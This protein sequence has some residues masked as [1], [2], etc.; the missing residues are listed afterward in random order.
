MPRVLRCV[1]LHTALQSLASV[2]DAPA[3][4]VRRAL[5]PAV[6]LALTDHRD[7]IGALATTLSRELGGVAHPPDKVHYFHGSRA[8]NPATF[9]SDGLHPLLASLD[10]VWSELAGLAPEI[11]A[12]D[13][14][15]LREDLT[16]GSIG[17]HTYSLRVNGKIDHGPCGGLVLDSLLHPDDYNAVDYLN[18]PE[19]TSDIC[20][21]VR[22]RFGVDIGTRY[23]EATTPCIVEFAMS[24]TNVD[25]ALASAAWYVEAAMRGRHTTNSNWGYDG[26]GKPVPAAA[27]V[28]VFAP[29]GTVLSRSA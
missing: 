2:F 28:S 17:P 18:G 7:P 19:I 14:S 1:D 24:A 15:R 9:A 16:A 12:I 20:H 29:G 25:Q 6:A 26:R 21:A 8:A 4:Q 27:I 13:L 5:V 3:D 23:R 22:E 11:P 10:I